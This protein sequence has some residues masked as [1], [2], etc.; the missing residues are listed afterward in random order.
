MDKNLTACIADIAFELKGIR[1]VLSAMWHSRYSNGET[2]VTNPD[3]YADEYISIEEC[4]KRLELT[5][6]KIRTW[7][8]MGRKDPETGWVEGVHYVNVGPSSDSRATIRIPW[9]FLI[10]TFSRGRPLN[11][12]DF[13]TPGGTPMYVSKAPKKLFNG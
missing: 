6:K 8:Q 10:Q 7:I 4:A 12:H 13:R 11:A 9:N 1:H 2:D 5:P 3:A